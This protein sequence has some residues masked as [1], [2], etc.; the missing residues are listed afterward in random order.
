MHQK[1]YLVR[2][3]SNSL[4][5]FQAEMIGVETA[6]DHPP[7][8]LIVSPRYSNVEK[9]LKVLLP[10][11][12][13]SIAQQFSIITFLTGMAIMHQS[14]S[15]SFIPSFNQSISINYSEVHHFANNTI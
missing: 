14:F 9:T 13:S 10:M 5:D 6:L 2:I 12:I 1:H 3:G 15:Q 8:C 11:L 7:Q 4:N